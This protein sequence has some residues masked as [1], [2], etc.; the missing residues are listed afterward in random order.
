M[1]TMEKT[2]EQSLPNIPTV[3]SNEAT[4][5]EEDKK[6][7]DKDKDE[8]L[9]NVRKKFFFD[10]NSLMLPPP[11]VDA[12]VL[13]VDAADPVWR[14]SY[15]KFTKKKPPNLFSKRYGT[16]SES[17]KMCLRSLFQHVSFLRYIY[18][19]TDNQK[20]SW[21]LLPHSQIRVVDHQELF[22]QNT[23]RPGVLET[24][25]FNSSAIEMVL[26][27]IPGLSPYFLYANDD[28][29]V[30]RA[31]K[32]SDWFHKEGHA[33][34]FLHH[35]K[36]KLPKY[37][38]RPLAEQDEFVDIKSKPPTQFDLQMFNVAATLGESSVRPAHQICVHHRFALKAVENCLPHTCAATRKSRLRTQDPFVVNINQ[39]T[40]IGW[41]QKLNLGQIDTQLSEM[42]NR[43][44]DFSKP[45]LDTAEEKILRDGFSEPLPMLCCANDH[46][47]NPL[48][49]KKFFEHLKR[50]LPTPAPWEKEISQL[51]TTDPST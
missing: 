20:P 37:L 32:R 17:L 12:V 46:E 14:A 40:A 25:T 29:F 38:Y 39:Y 26:H 24:P 42:D 19:V 27:R 50:I 35:A 23:A 51:E 7:T 36:K 44:L 18:L 8:E 41:M 15:N 6:E 4:T 10:P 5:D 1:N 47:S 43:Y 30:L 13:W 2:L 45:R 49:A 34:I 3:L 11:P 22:N 9:R 33:R 21:L 16:G 31:T 28:M 48:R